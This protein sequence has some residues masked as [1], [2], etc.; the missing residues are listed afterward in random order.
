MEIETFKAI[1]FPKSMQYS[2]DSERIPLEFY[3]EAFPRSKKIDM[4]LGYFSSNALKTLCR[5]FAEFVY[6]GGHMRIVTN[7]E[8]SYEDKENL[9]I[10]TTLNDEDKLIDIFQDLEQL[11][12][13]L[14]P[15][16]IHF[17]DC[18]KFLLDKKRL[19]FQ[20]V[21]HAPDN[22]SHYKEIILFDGENYLYAHGS[23]NFTLAG[24]IKNGESFTVDKSWNSSEAEL[25]RI[26][27]QLKRFELI[28]EK[29]HKSYKYLAPKDVIGIIRKIGNSRNE[30]ELLEDASNLNT[31]YD[32][33][34]K[35]RRIFKKRDEIFKSKVD[36]IREQMKLDEN[37]PKFPIKKKGDG[38]RPYQKIAYDNWKNNN[39]RGLFAMATGTGKTLTALYCLIKEFKIGEAQQNIFIVPGEELVRQWANDL[40]ECNFQNIF[41]WYGKNN[42]LNDDINDIKNLKDKRCLN[43]VITYD[44]FRSPKFQDLFENNFSNF[45]LIFDEAHTIGGNRNKTIIGNIITNHLIGLSATPL[46]M[47][48]ENNENEFIEVLFNSKY[49]DYTFSFSMEDAIKQGY[50]CKYEYHPYF[51]S[52]IDE[53]F[54]EYLLETSKIPKGINGKINS[55][56]AIRRQ[57]ILDGAI[58]KEDKLHEIILE[59]TKERQV[60]F[61]LVYCAKGRNSQGNRRIY[62][63]SKKIKRAFPENE[64]MYFTSETSN[65]EIILK[66]FEK[67]NINMLFSIKCLDQGIN[68]PRTETGIFLAS[69]KNYREFVQRRG[70]ILRTYNKNGIKKELSYI[71]DIVVI[72]TLQQFD[73]F[74]EISKKLIISEFKRLFEFSKMA[75]YNQTAYNKIEAELMKYGYTQNYIE[76][77]IEL[78]KLND[79]QL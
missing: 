15:H 4:L 27:E 29:K 68:I 74:K 43:I 8:L 7:H 63:L 21:K 42:K 36:K 52:L 9:L 66:D 37:K 32:I 41:L 75:I 70:R 19:T 51:V 28:F 40:Y 76:H 59:I 48:D 23:C 16:G 24:L 46:R 71:Y 12:E 18:L 3:E 62:D 73:K 50:L 26:S 67:G 38:P 5:G 69:G 55:M 25:I 53:E 45:T 20:T 39:C 22:L 35:V 1:D 65:R 56:A 49:P 77:E 14:G 64:V 78:S 17:F 72:P 6:N 33:P 61:S 54:N 57:S 31:Q 47:W 79:Q 60:Q 2:S 11:K 34:E 58:K 10:N 13:Q 30:L 44:S